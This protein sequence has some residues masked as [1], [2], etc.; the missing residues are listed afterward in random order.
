MTNKNTKSRVIILGAGATGLSAGLRFVNRGYEVFI[1]EKAD[2]A[3][4][5]A[6]TITRGD[7]RLDIG[8]HHLFSQNEAILKEI[9][10]LFEKDELTVFNRDARLY[11]H[12]RY[13][14][15]PLTAKNVLFHMGFKHALL[16]STSYIW[17]IIR[18]LFIKQGNDETFTT[19]IKNNFGS[20]LYRI[21]FKPYTEQF[22]G[23]PCEE[24]SIDCIPLASKLSFMKTLKLLFLKRF[25]SESLSVAERDTTLT[26]YYPKKG[27]GEIVK[28]MQAAFL[29]KGGK[30][31]MGCSLS[32]L[33]CNENNTFTAHYQ[34]NIGEKVETTA[35]HV[36]STIPIP[37]LVQVMTPAVPA[38]I[39][40]S[41]NKLEYLSTIVLYIVIT[42]RDIF[43]CAYLYLIN[44]P[45]NRVSNVNRFHSDLCPKGEN[46]LALEITCHF[47]DSVWNSSDDELF[48][49]C[50]PHLK[51]DDFIDESEVKQYFSIRVKSAYPFYRLGY[52]EHLGKIREYFERMPNLVIAG[53]TGAFKYMDIDQCMEDTAKLADR[54]DKD[55]TF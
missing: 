11:F 8:P 14:D 39:I 36:I 44:R 22:W 9:I 10:D 40:E 53:R 13:L 32:N 46:M 42:D 26:L 45:Y 24:L 23:I 55:G 12:D 15:Y 4:G 21:F 29:A 20:Y 18:Q 47:N 5:L 19:W 38:E 33:S 7:Y 3:G 50:I 48:E 30:I 37:S 17:T 1:L 27:V 49:L 16:S 54:F 43:D 51:A 35:T 28:K 2:H 52:R 41:A 31:E 25:N 34:S 6:K